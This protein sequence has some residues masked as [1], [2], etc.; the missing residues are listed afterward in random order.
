MAIV[1]ISVCTLNV[2]PLFSESIFY[3]L[4][5]PSKYIEFFIEIIIYTTAF[6]A[7]TKPLEVIVTSVVA[8]AVILTG[9]V[10]AQR[11]LK[12]TPQLT[13]IREKAVFL[14]AT[15]GTLFY[16]V[17]L[18]NACFDSADLKHTDFRKANLT[19][20]SFKGA[21]G[22]E[23]ARLQG[24]I[25]EQ[26]RVRKLLTTLNGCGEDFTEADLCGANLRGANLKEVRSRN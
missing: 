3:I 25:L 14:A 13:W 8:I 20:T 17:D 21:M 15:G 18:T 7:E 10:I 1:G 23:L 12:E 2:I 6:Y 26:P 9:A 24:T 16:G 11:A 19:R 5:E 22:L 4:R